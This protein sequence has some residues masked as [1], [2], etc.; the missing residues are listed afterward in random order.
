MREGIGLRL[1]VA[2]DRWLEGRRPVKPVKHSRAPKSRAGTRCG[3]YTTAD[4][5]A[6]GDSRHEILW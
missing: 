4:S 2:V 1:L 3:K 5:L 6:Q